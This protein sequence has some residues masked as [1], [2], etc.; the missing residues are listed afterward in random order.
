MYIVSLDVDQRLR[1]VRMFYGDWDSL[2]AE[3][4]A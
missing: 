2:F 3:A 1:E 4:A